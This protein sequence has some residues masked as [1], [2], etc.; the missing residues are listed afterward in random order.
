MKLKSQKLEINTNL[1]NINRF[2]TASVNKT[3]NKK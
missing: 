3:V 1:K 2:F